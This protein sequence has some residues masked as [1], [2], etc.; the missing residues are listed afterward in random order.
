MNVTPSIQSQTCQQFPASF[1]AI[2]NEKINPPFTVIVDDP[3]LTFFKE[4]MNFRE[5][6]IQHTINDVMKFY[7]ETYGLDFSLSSPNEK[8]EYFYQNAKLSPFEMTDNV[9]YLVTVNNWIRTGST[10]SNCYQIRD[11]GFRVTF[12]ADQ[13][14]RGTY[15]GESG[16]V[17]G[18]TEP[19]FYGFY[20]ID[21]CEQSPVIIQYQSA[22]PLRQVPVDGFSIINCD[23][24]SR[25]LGYGKA[26]GVFIL[27]QD[28]EDPNAFRLS[29]RNAFT[30]PAKENETG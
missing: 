19:L 16:V 22:S 7:N 30:F 23:V 1:L 6:A 21:V 15:G 27:T 4:I 11:G 2:I 12:S 25:T 3:K 26:Q 13:T 29:G 10:R 28:P 17:V 9:E 24:Y 8:N 18:V 20:N 5:D 14:L